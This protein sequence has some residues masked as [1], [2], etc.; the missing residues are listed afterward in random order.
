MAQPYVMAL[1]DVIMTVKDGAGHLPAALDS[2]AAQTLRDFRLLACDDGSTDSTADIFASERRFPVVLVRNGKNLGI[3]ASANTLLDL[4]DARYIAR[5]D[6][7]DVCEPERFAKQVAFLEAH[8]EVGVLGTGVTLIDAAGNTIGRTR[9][10]ETD[11]DIRLGLLN[12]CPVAQPAVMLRASVVRDH[13]LRYD[14]SLDS[15]E[16]YDLWCRLSRHTKLANLRECLTR[17]RRHGSAEYLEKRRVESL[18]RMEIVR[19]RYLGMLGFDDDAARLFA[20]LHRPDSGLNRVSPAATLAL[21]AAFDRAFAAERDPAFRKRRDNI[22]LSCLVRMGGADKLRLFARAP[23]VLR[24]YAVFRF[25]GGSRRRSARNSMAAQKAFSRFVDRTVTARGG[26]VREPVRIYGAAAATRL[27][28]GEATVIEHGCSLWFSEPDHDDQGR[29]SA[30]DYLF[31][32]FNVRIDVH[33]DIGIGRQVSI[34]ANSYITSG[35]HRYESR[36]TPI[37]S[38]GFA[39]APV[40][41]D[42]DVWIGC[43]VV[44]LPGVHVGRGA[45]IG[46]GS[47]VTRDVPPFEIWGGVPAKKLKDR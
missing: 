19:A 31:L 46:A 16:D 47:V 42:D 40:R 6:G 18:K 9:Y 15:S 22:A 3:S 43:N 26:Q 11:A 20:E 39:G 35:N 32:G 25:G 41:I 34:G 28:L 4:A 24:A 12:A 44:V 17:Y 36:E 21:L 10:P 38:Q 5:F 8:P 13:G 30:G 29:L 33:A 14:T 7:D 37:Q 2:L 45:V 1:I 27:S 23:S